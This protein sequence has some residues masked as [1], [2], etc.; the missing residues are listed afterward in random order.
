MQDPFEKIIQNWKLYVEKACQNAIAAR[1]ILQEIKPIFKDDNLLIFEVANTIAEK[2]IKDVMNPLLHLIHSETNVK[3]RYEIKINQ[4]SP[5]ES[6]IIDPDE[7]F[8]KMLETNPSLLS[9]KQQLNL[10]II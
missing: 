1:S 7:K 4:R 10:S 6:R 3:F 9:F 5:K 8:K 2:E